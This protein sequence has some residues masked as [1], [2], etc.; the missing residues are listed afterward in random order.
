MADSRKSLTIETKVEPVA[1]S[2]LNE[3]PIELGSHI[4]NHLNQ[5]SLY[6]ASLV[7]RGVNKL[8][9]QT[10]TAAKLLHYVLRADYDAVEKII[11]TDPSLIFQETNYMRSD[12]GVESISS[13]NYSFKVYDTYMYKLFLEK[14]V[15]NQ[16]HIDLYK[17][18]A[19][20]QVKHINLQPL[21]VEYINFKRKLGEWFECKISDQSLDHEWL[22]V[23]IKQR[24]L[25]PTHM[26][27][28]FC[29]KVDCWYQES[30]FDVTTEARP[31]PIKIYNMETKVYVNS[32]PGRGIAK[33]YST[34]YKVPE[35]I[36]NGIRDSSIRWFAKDTEIALSMF[37]NLFQA[38]INDFDS[39]L[40]L[41]DNPE[42]MKL[43]PKL[44][45]LTT[46]K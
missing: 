35:S 27:R 17:S 16:N 45:T 8:F 44:K 1:S 3:L 31:G 32:L 11:D 22:K 15:D 23:A 12:G 28:E 4:G 5:T 7:S 10:L 14:I 41:L 24:E 29:R 34:C 40:L 6:T 42:Q 19:H 30:T 20:K 9:Q 46:S 36:A 13:L 33:H 18:L 38:R 43:K 37:I 21:L 26:L 2:S 25:L 39:L